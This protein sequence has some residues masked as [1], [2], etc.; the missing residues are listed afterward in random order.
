MLSLKNIK[1]NLQTQSDHP[2]NSTAISEMYEYKK[3]IL[4]T[5][6]DIILQKEKTILPQHT[7]LRNAQICFTYYTCADN[8]IC[9]IYIVKDN[10]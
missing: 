4:C 1:Y 8:T 3:I 2:C 5:F 10:K 6:S 7:S 9:S